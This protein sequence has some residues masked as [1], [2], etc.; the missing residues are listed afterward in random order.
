[1]KGKRKMLL[2][3]VLSVLTALC[4]QF[5]AFAGNY[6]F[7]VPHKVLY[8]GETQ[9]V[10]TYGYS[11]KVYYSSGNKNSFTVSENGVIKALAPSVSSGITLKVSAAG[12]KQV[13]STK[14]IIKKPYFTGKLKVTA[15][16]TTKLAFHSNLLQKVSWSS[17]S[18]NV[19]RIVS[20]STP[21]GQYCTVKGVKAGTAL[22]KAS[23][24]GSTYTCKVTVSSPNVTPTPTPTPRPT[25]SPTPKPEPEDTLTASPQ[26][27]TCKRVARVTL[28][29]SKGGTFNVSVS[30]EDVAYA[31]WGKTEK[32]GEMTAYIIGKKNDTAVVTFTHKDTGKKT[33]AKVTFTGMELTASDC[34]TYLTERLQSRKSDTLKTARNGYSCSSSIALNKKGAVVFKTVLKGKNDSGTIRLI[35]N[36]AFTSGK[37]IY[38]GKASGNGKAFRLTAK[39]LPGTCKRNETLPIKAEGNEAKLSK[40]KQKNI[41]NTAKDAAFFSWNLLL[42]DSLSLDLNSLGFDSYEA[43]YE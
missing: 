15:G 6:G 4:V 8:V 35:M 34:V 11:G 12:N 36:K 43:V 38:A 1:M 30:P 32:K 33:S 42:A 2:A 21:N 18:T 31:K 9:T 13:T 28:K 23:Y 19:V 27:Q 24:C 16:E 14:L 26:T 20:T 10:K 41:G 37:L 17:S 29:H 5:P 7:K 25:P 39:I 22:V 40:A 3:A